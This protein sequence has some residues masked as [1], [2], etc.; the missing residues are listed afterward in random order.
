MKF[1]RLI[2]NKIKQLLKRI[3]EQFKYRRTIRKIEKG[4]MDIPPYF[5]IE[6]TRENNPELIKVFKL[7]DEGELE[8]PV[9]SKLA[10]L[11]KENPIDIDKL[12]SSQVDM[13]IYVNKPD[14]IRNFKI[15]K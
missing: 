15:D 5:L 10:R 8:E 7:I 12:L 2:I 1:S 6:K 13:N 4:E 3:S 11:F 9:E 14:N